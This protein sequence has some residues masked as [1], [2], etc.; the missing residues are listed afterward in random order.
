MKSLT[1]LCVLATFVSSCVVDPEC[2]R[3]ERS[4]GHL[5]LQ[6]PRVPE[7]IRLEDDPGTTCARQD[8]I[9]VCGDANYDLSGARL[10]QDD[11]TQ[12]LVSPAPTPGETPHQG[13]PGAR[14]ARRSTP[15]T[16]ITDDVICDD[17]T[18]ARLGDFSSPGTLSTRSCTSVIL[19]GHG[20]RVIWQLGSEL[21]ILVPGGAA[22]APSCTQ[23]QSVVEC[24]DASAYLESE[25]GPLV[26]SQ[27]SCTRFEIEGAPLEVVARC[28]QAVSCE[29]GDFVCLSSAV[30]NLSPACE[31][32]L[33][34]NIVCHRDGGDPLVLTPPTPCH[35]PKQGLHLR[36]EQDAEELLER[37]CTVLF[38]DVVMESGDKEAPDL[39]LLRALAKTRVIQGS[40]QVM[41]ATLPGGEDATREFFKV[42]ESLKLQVVSGEVRWEKTEAP[43]LELE[44][45]KV[46]SGDV[47]L[48]GNAKLTHIGLPSTLLHVGGSVYVSGHPE[49]QSTPRSRTPRLPNIEGALVW[50]QNAGD[51]CD[52]ADLLTWA[53]GRARG[54][55]LA[56]MTQDDEPI[57]P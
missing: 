31:A 9:I 20:R 38:G 23:T 12:M 22:S 50:G 7:P 55:L 19:P 5:E 32:A 56:A 16:I 34:P 4:D 21:T 3:L 54:V 8:D 44:R 1:Y 26:A 40:L 24:S 29:A 27:E 2:T 18:R 33:T 28:I 17:G 25:G 15:C 39:R 14:G 57:C 49:L 35:L 45:L 52:L 37:E 53:L 6:C 42:L 46:I 13:T 48:E 36:E 47:V 43:F 11:P 10:S 41:G 51:P 30:E